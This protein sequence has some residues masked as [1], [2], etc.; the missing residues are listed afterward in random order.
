MAIILGLLLLNMLVFVL[1]RE[2]F[3]PFDHSLGELL[4]LKVYVSQ[5][6]PDSIE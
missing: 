2:G 5:I 3:K 1:K 6:I 4:I